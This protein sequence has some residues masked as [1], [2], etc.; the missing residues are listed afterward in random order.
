MEAGHE[1]SAGEWQAEWHLVPQIMSLASSALLRAGELA[2]QLVINTNA[3]EQNLLADQGLLM[4]E[5]Y[6]IAL[7]DLMGREKAH[8]AVYEACVQ[9]RLLNIPLV[10]VLVSS[11]NATERTIVSELRPRDYIGKAEVICDTV[12]ESWR[13]HTTIAKRGKKTDG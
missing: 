4:A 10:Q 9:A 1:R 11:L 5:A 7:S 12:T 2:S 6:M 3:I 8:D 13:A